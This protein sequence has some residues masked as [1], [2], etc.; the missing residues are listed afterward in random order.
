[1]GIDWWLL[2]A[3]IALIGIGLI[4]LFSEGAT[5]DG[6][7]N[8]RKQLVNVGLGLGPFAMM[9]LV[10]PGAWRRTWKAVYGVN[11]LALVAVLAVGAS[12]KGAER[13][14]PIGPIQFQPSELSK[15]LVVLTLSAFLAGRYDE[16]KRPGTFLL[17]GLHVVVPVSLIM[18]QPHLGASMVIMAAWVAILVVGGVPLK[19]L[20][21]SAGV[22]ALLVGLVA[23]P[24]TRRLVLRPYQEARVVGMMSSM[25][26]GGKEEQGRQRRDKNYQTDQAAIAFG[27]G[28]VTGTGY[29]NGERKKAHFIPEQHNDFAITIIGEE[30]GLLGCTILLALFGLFFYRCWLAIYHADNPYHRMISAGVLTVI[31]FH[32]L[33]NMA[34]VLQMA[35]VVGLWLPFISYGGTAMWL[36]MGCV[37]LM[38]NLRGRERPVLF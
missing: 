30:F 17:A 7:A 23:V 6:G 18:L 13:W 22:F 26:L 15:L 33:V 32:M 16:I 36:C 11:L 27:V 8:F 21:I 35:P 5:R 37:G 20:G 9:L 38:L 24:A 10:S 1:A 2:G 12:K 34:M 29:L 28:G 19:Y 4:A 14:I 3:S 31:A 25:G